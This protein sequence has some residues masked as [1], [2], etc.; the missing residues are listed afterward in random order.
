MTTP[1]VGSVRFSAAE[2]ARISGGDDRDGRHLQCD[3]ELMDA[4][5][6]AHD[7]GKFRGSAGLMREVSMVPVGVDPCLRRIS[8]IVQRDRVPMLRAGGARRLGACPVISV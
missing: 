2:M 7:P 4:G 6:S 8:L 3:E 5:A 1:S